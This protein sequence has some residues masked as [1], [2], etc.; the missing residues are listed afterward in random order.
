MDVRPFRGYRHAAGGD[1]SA[2]VA[3]PYD[4]I[5]P[6]LQERL[7][8]LDPENIVRVT[9]PRDG[10]DKYRDARTRLDAWLAQG[11]WRRDAEPAIYPYHQIY[12]AGGA[13]VTR[14]GFIA[15]GEVT[16][17]ATGEVLP[18]ERT[19]AGPKRDRLE[20]LEAT[21]ADV[22][23][24][25]M[26]ASDPD[27][28]LLRATTPAAAPIAEARDLKGE[29]HRLWRLTDAA[30]L[31]RVRELMAG[32]SVIIADGHHR[33]ETAVE[34]RR[35]H[36]GVTHK[37]MAFFTLEAPGLTILPNHR[38]VHDVA[39]F[40]FEDLMAVAARWFD[41][42][43]LADPLAFR[44]EP[45][46]I[47][48]VAGPDAAVLRLRPDRFDWIRWPEDT[49]RAWR[50]LAVSILHEGILRPLL[51]ITNETL[52]ARTHVDYT[53]DQ[54]EAVA[55]ARAGKIQAAFLIA[56]TTPEELQAVV[57]GGELMPQKSTHFYPKLLD[58]L[59][60]QVVDR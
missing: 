4:Q 52:E 59:V 45:R 60:F 11:V 57:R 48:I 32:R 56:P 24:L 2:V 20:L 43:P 16:D 26:L 8:A 25:F 31:G 51:G 34:Y 15:L 18:H 55:L 9:L 6:E 5:G 54:A 40:D 21:G 50:E 17:Y 35:R 33:Y 19:H 53:A 58:G 42:A 12:Q 23:L 29:T 27:G 28:E 14:T 46:L 38:L 10:G 44:A 47:G 41:V 39:H 1:V 7:H 13:T 22:G 37:L 3:P 49:S 36:P 30:T